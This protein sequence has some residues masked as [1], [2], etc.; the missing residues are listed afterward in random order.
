M[1]FLKNG[2][3]ICKPSNRDLNRDWKTRLNQTFKYF[4]IF[5][6][7]EIDNLCTFNNNDFE[8]DYNDKAG[9]ITQRGKWR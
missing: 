6:D 7:L 2:K 5:L 8:S 3:K 1:H 4:Q 9:A